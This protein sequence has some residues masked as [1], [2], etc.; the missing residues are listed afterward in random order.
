MLPTSEC[1]NKWPKDLAIKNLNN[2]SLHI[3]TRRGGLSFDCY[4]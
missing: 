2:H 3:N 4:F 1:N